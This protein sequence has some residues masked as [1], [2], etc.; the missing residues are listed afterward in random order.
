MTRR[1]DDN[2]LDSVLEVLI[3]SGLDGMADAMATLMNEAMKIE[4]SRFLGAEP[5]ERSSER[6]GCVEPG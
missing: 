6:A 1:K 3:E 5:H 2:A 4:R